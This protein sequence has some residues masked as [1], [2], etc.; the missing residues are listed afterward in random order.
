MNTNDIRD[1]ARETEERIIA[2]RHQLHRRP[3][4]GFREKETAALVAKELAA[5]PLTVETGIYGTGICAVLGGGP[6]KTILLRADMDALPIQENTGL[7]YS[8]EISGVM[9]AC[10]HDGHTAILLGTAIVLSRFRDQLPGT[11]KFVFQ[12]AEESEGGAEGMIRAGVLNNPP[13]DAATGL[14]LWGSTPSGIVEYR[15]GPLM[16]SPDIFS[17]RVI[18]RGGHAAKPHDCIDPVPIAAS[19]I[20]Q[21]QTVVSRQVDPLESVVVSVCRVAAGNT[22]NVIPDEALLQGTV[23]ALVPEVREKI[24][25]LLERVVKE[26][27]AMYG[28]EYRFEYSYRYPPLVNDSAITNLVRDAAE[29]VVGRE[30]VREAVQPNMGGEDFAYFAEA[31]PSSFFY[32]GIAPSEDE[33]VHH[34]HPTFRIDDAVL[35]DGIAI[36]SQIAFDFLRLDLR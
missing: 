20:Q 24:P 19:I 16:A 27:T 6:G 22:H 17:I 30:R 33:I 26:T 14:H 13:V 3:E 1:A 10:G 28:A 4:L 9:H 34:H 7:P 5:L 23:R 18:G 31:V 32:L 15:A 35:K 36:F 2:F 8:S 11:V 12:P 25:A 21:F 29:K